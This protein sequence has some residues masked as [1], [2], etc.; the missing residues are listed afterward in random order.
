MDIA[1]AAQMVTLLTVHVFHVTGRI[2]IEHTPEHTL[3]AGAEPTVRPAVSDHSS[4]SI[5]LL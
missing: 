2:A 1:A 4:I 3:D 5:V